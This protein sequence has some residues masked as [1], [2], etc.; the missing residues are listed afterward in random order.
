MVV[1]VVGNLGMADRVVQFV[2]RVVEVVNVKL[3]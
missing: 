3:E 2:G 1:V